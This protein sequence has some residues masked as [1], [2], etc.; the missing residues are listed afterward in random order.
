VISE[1]YNTPEGEPL[2]PMLVSV[3]IVVA[4]A[5]DWSLFF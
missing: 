4:S 5:V 1:Q 2:W 3:L